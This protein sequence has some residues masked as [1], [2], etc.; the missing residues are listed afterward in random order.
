MHL[1]DQLNPQ[2]EVSDLAFPD[3]YLGNFHMTI[4]CE[5]DPET[6]MAHLGQ[7]DEFSQILQM[8]SDLIVEEIYDEFELPEEVLEIARQVRE[9]ILV[10][11]GEG[12]EIPLYYHHA[13]NYARVTFSFEDPE[14][15]QLTYYLQGVAKQHPDR[16]IA[17][18]GAV[19][20][21]EVVRVANLVQKI[22]FDTTIVTRYCISS[23]SL[24]N[25]DDLFYSMTKEEHRQILEE[26]SWRKDFP[27]E[28]DQA[29]TGG[30]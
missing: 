11:V 13:V 22:G 20:E 8:H 17:V 18:I 28:E 24:I 1:L 10:A 5:P 23:Q 27:E 21:D 7:E 3:S 25:L 30:K 15:E 12:P 9:P 19:F 2:I 16:R 29:N 14:Y 26:M 6:W 4:L